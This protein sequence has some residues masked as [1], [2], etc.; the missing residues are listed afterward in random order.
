MARAAEIVQALGAAVI[1]VNMGCPARK[2]VSSRSGAALLR[3]PDRARRVLR[4]MRRVAR[5]PLTVK[6][7]WDWDDG[8]A[9]RGSALEILRA[10]EEEGVDG[11]CLHARTREQGYAGTAN[12]ERIAEARRAAPEMPLVGNG[13][14]RAPADALEMLRRSGCD[15][16]M[17][18]RAVIGDPWL[19]GAALRAIRGD[20]LDSA[21]CARSDSASYAPSWPERRATMLRHARMMA[22]RRGERA[23]VAFRKHAAAYLRGLPGAKRLRA[24]IMRVQTLEGLARALD[25]ATV[26]EL[27]A[28][29]GLGGPGEPGDETPC[30]RAD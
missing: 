17:I 10:A 20:R 3:D 13:D 14:V 4:A 5:V 28:P 23:V 21:P 25:A 1:D 16:V 18:G 30:P 8:Q 6:A 7:R 22:D 2:I 12:W 27:A 24:E 15:A 26:T 19:L 11:F 29:S 9:G